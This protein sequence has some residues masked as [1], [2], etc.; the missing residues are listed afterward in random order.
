[1]KLLL[2]FVCILVANQNVLSLNNEKTPIYETPEIRRS[3]SVIIFNP[4]FLD[5]ISI[6][7]L[8]TLINPP[9]L[10]PSE[11]STPEVT[12]SEDSHSKNLKNGLKEFL[13]LT[14]IKLLI[15]L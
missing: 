12:S 3:D 4:R 14:S 13:Q 6:L 8:K 5:K 2:L 1:M 15:T 11:E 10:L 7:E 9:N